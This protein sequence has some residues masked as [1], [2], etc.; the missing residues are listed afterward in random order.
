VGDEPTEEGEVRLD[1][2]HLGLVK[3]GGERVEGGALLVELE[4]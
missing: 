2:A 4:E 1:P 3:R